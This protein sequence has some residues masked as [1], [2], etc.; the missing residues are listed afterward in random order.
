ME[1]W[2]EGL[3]DANMVL[4][5][6]R[7]ELNRGKDSVVLTGICD[8]PAPWEYKVTVMFEDWT[9]VLNTATADEARQFLANSVPFTTILCMGWWMVKFVG[10]MA[11]FRFAR[12]V[13]L[14]GGNKTP[15]EPLPNTETV[16]RH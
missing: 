13:G 4:D 3:G 6:E 9:A 2:S 14:S 10:L 12:I 1:Y 7:A 16:K 8:A 5:L 15:Q 11:A